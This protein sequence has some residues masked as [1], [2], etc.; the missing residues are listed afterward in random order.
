MREQ[1][2]EEIANTLTPRR[3]PVPAFRFEEFRELLQIGRVRAHRQGREPFL[4]LE[5]I[6]KPSDDTLVGGVHRFQYGRAMP[7]CKWQ[8]WYRFP[9]A[10]PPKKPFREHAPGIMTARARSSG[11]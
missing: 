11:G 9:H 1:T 6:E 3:R 7:G 10:T 2:A 5:I 4:D 8:E